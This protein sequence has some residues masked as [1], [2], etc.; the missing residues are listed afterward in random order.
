MT[1]EGTYT[2]SDS[3]ITDP[4]E[5]VYRK[6]LTRIR[7]TGTAPP[8]TDWQVE[9]FPSTGFPE[10]Q[11]K[12]DN[13]A[14]N[15]VRETPGGTY[16]YWSTQRA[17][18]FLLPSEITSPR[19]VVQ[20]AVYDETSVTLLGNL[21]TGRNDALRC[22]IRDQAAYVRIESRGVPWALERMSVLVEPYGHTKNVKG[23]Y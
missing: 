12:R 14:E 8:N 15:T 17:A 5:R 22:R 18:G 21:T 7:N 6:T 3:L 10:P 1:P 23:T 19:Y 2:T 20:T 9:S 11:Y 4:T 16:F 13:A